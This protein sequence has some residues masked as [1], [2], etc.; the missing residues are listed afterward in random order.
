MKVDIQ[1]SSQTSIHGEGT[2]IDY[3][4]KHYYYYY[5]YYH[6]HYR[7]HHHEAVGVDRLLSMLQ[8]RSCAALAHLGALVHEITRFDQSLELLWLLQPLS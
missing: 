7:Y 6:Y 4:G 8:F 2:R 3:P 5:Y 1:S